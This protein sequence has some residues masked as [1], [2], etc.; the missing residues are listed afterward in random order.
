MATIKA[1]TS[2]GE[3]GADIAF[4]DAQLTLEKDFETGRV[5]LYDAAVLPTLTIRRSIKSRPRFAVMPAY[6]DPDRITGLSEPLSKQEI[7]DL[8][9]AREFALKQLG[10]PEGLRILGEPLK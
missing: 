5:T 6:A 8:Q 10:S 7:K 1:F 9:K 3:A 2:A 4:D